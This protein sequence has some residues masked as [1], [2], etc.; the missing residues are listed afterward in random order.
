MP[1]PYFAALAYSYE[2]LATHHP[3]VP[4]YALYWAQ[5]L[6]KAGLFGEASRCM[7]GVE[8]LAQALRLL[9]CA[10][11]YEQVCAQGGGAMTLQRIHVTAP[12]FQGGARRACMHLQSP[13]APA[14]SPPPATFV[15]VPGRLGWLPHRAGGLQP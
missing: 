5:S 1:P 4:E 8:G 14:C 7:A 10:I 13:P 2:A 3:G 12:W 15:C 9:S 6:Y 11:K